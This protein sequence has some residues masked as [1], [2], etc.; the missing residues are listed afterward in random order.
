MY[1]LNIY[2]KSAQ[3]RGLLCKQYKQFSVR[4]KKRYDLTKCQKRYISDAD[5]LKNLKTTKTTMV[6]RESKY[7][8]SIKTLFPLVRQGKY[9]KV[10]T[11]VRERNIDIN[12]HD[13]FENTLLTD[14]AKRGDIYT[15]R[16]LVLD[17]EAN[18]HASCDCPYHKTALHYASENGH[19]DIVEFLLD[20][21]ALPNELDS[22]R[23]T[24][25]DIAKNDS[26]RKLLV[27]KNGT[28]GTKIQINKTQQL[29]LPKK[30]CP[31]I[32]Q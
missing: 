3:V 14:A 12:S 4:N 22:R 15:V 9:N 25:L 21:G 2:L 19:Y 10:K 30:D 27:S 11:L 5:I 17:M 8:E 18:V 13:K 31:S 26:I 1:L 23:Y 20:H 28:T 32:A 6:I 29:N 24:A 7:D 16:F